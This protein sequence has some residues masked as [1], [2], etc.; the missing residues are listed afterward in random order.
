M[1]ESA[2]AL[3]V[4]QTILSLQD[5]IEFVNSR[6]INRA[7][8]VEQIFCA[9][10]TGE[11]ALVQSRTGVAKSLMTEQIFRMFTGARYFKVQ[12][13]KEQ[14]PD[15]YFGGM[16]LE[17]LKK[18]RIVHNTAGSLVESEF[19]FI[20]EI[21]DANDYTLRSLLSLLNER[22]LILGV[23]HQHAAIHTVVAATNYLRISEIT[24]A[25]LDRFSY[26][27]V[28]YPD[29]D[30]YAQYL[31]SQQYLRHGGQAAAPPKQIDYS[32]LR[33][34]T[35]ICTG[36]SEQ[37]TITIPPEVA[38]YANVVIRY[39]EELRNRQ[40]AGRP[41]LMPGRD[42][43]IS[44]RKQM[45]ALDLLRAIAFMHGRSTVS[46]DD[47]D[48]L[49]VLFTTIGIEEERAIWTKASQTL[50]HQ[51][52]ATNA[53]EQL[54]TLLDYKS[55]IDQLKRDPEQ[56]RQPL[57]ELDNMPIKRTLREWARETFG[58]AD[59]NT[60][61]NRRLLEEFLEKLQ[62]MTDEVR[63]LKQQLQRDLRILFQARSGNDSPLG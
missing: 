21:F 49:Y 40:L 61:N 60:E 1:V 17:E 23:Q 5:A 14:Q 10:L 57:T 51:F 62:P 34:V 18:G 11:H 30:P 31:I 53:M 25:L 3:N 8:V 26:Q 39:Y 50:S 28:I 32:L 24:E 13:S 45:K 33:E 12:A 54:K 4:Q 38:Y 36:R 19:G 35:M 58:R 2:P 44:P 48:K 20:D 7:D 15:T 63:D 29:K 55:M 43:Y 56:L 27:S 46:Q 9:L 52:S 41:E 42:F 47:V 59:V 37:M 6:V 16:D 22:E